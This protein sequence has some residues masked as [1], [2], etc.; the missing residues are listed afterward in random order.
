MLLPYYIAA[1]NIARLYKLTGL[2][3]EAPLPPSGA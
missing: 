1:L 2:Q 3:L